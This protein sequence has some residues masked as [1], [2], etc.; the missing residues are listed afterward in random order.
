MT[1]LLLD[2]EKSC[3]SWEASFRNVYCSKNVKLLLMV[4]K[5]VESIGA[6]QIDFDHS[7]HPFVNLWSS[8]IIS[9]ALLIFAVFTDIFFC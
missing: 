7:S 5:S 1:T 3:M 4:S 2:S 6:L 8:T 9:V